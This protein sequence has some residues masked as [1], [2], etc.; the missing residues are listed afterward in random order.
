MVKILE[1]SLKTFTNT[2]EFLKGEVPATILE[3]PEM[4][5]QDPATTLEAPA[6][7]RLKD[8]CKDHQG[9]LC[10]IVCNILKDFTGS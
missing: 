8:P 10:R 4:I 7:I 9:S 2:Y 1:G 3:V 5:L 6:K